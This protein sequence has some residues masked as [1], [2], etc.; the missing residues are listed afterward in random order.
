MEFAFR[1]REPA[2]RNVVA[3]IR[4]SVAFWEPYADVGFAR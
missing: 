2:D 3:M 1:E 4:E